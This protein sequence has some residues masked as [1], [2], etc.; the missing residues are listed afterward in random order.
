MIQRGEIREKYG[1][2]GNGCTDCLLA[3][4]C[5]P[6]DLTQQDKEV[7]TREGEKIAFIS[8]QPAAHEGMHYGGPPPAMQSPPV[9]ATP[10]LV[11]EKQEY[12]PSQSQQYVAAPQY[13]APQHNGAPQQYTH[14]QPYGA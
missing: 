7:Q 9:V 1:L 3:C 4:Y 6:C 5:I 10:P 11:G 12:H 14:A 2:K 8:Q 13:S